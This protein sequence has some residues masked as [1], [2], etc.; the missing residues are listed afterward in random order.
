MNV[1]RY[2]EVLMEVMDHAADHA[3]DGLG[4]AVDRLCGG[5]PP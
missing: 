3:A 4:G 1:A 2:R 5:Q